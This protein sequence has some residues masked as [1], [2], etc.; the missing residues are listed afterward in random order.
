L[1]RTY[2]PLPLSDESLA[3][4]GRVA[5]ALC[6]RHGERELIS[7]TAALSRVYTR[8]RGQMQALESDSRALLARIGFFWARD[9]T[10]VFGPLDE[11]LGAGLIARRAS[12]RVLD[13]G[14][15][16]GATSFGLARWLRLRALPTRSLDVVA[17][18]QS[19]SAL[20]AFD[21]L[22]RSLSGLPDELAPIRLDARAGNLH[23]SRR[24]GAFDLILL[25]FVLNELFLDLPVAERVARRAALLT[26]AAGQ[27]AEGGAIIVLEPA[28]KETTRELM[29]LRDVLAARAA[30]PYV[31]APCLHARP[32]PMLPSERDWCHQELPYALPPALATIARAAGLRYEGLSY[33]SLVLANQPRP[34]QSNRHRVVS[35]RLESKGKL[36]LFSCSEAGYVRLSRLTRDASEDNAPFGEAR[37]GD[38]LTLSGAPGRIGKDSKVSRG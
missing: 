36:E 34:G 18:E 30:A 28:L 4:V 8:E 35:D 26:E 6:G 33:A 20:R 29:Q 7:A 32:C 37:R 14:A 5:H 2:E 25:G 9:L 24:D 22:A 21:A 31:I 11:L 10:K 27:L 1:R 23:D 38:I 17:L 19:K 12:L 16:L 15:G 3:R 13:V